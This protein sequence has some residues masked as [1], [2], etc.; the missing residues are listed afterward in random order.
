MT[1]NINFMKRF[2][3]FLL[4]A[5]VTMAFPPVSQAAACEKPVTEKAA[6]EK[7]AVEEPA[8][9]KPETEKSADK[10]VSFEAVTLRLSGMRMTME[11]EIV[12]NGEEAQVV[13]YVMRYE[14]K[15]KKRE[16]RR[17]AS[18]GADRVLRLLNRCELISWDGFAGKHPAGVLDGT[19]FTL[20]ACVN[21]GRKISAGG[22]EN[23]PKHFRELRNGLD[24]IL[25]QRG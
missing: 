18:C 5:A 10:I 14:K 8:V 7:P 19:A 12:M 9:E 24:A 13:E 2:F 20:K 23:F 15:E 22:S 4:L 25:R 17:K 6:A 1:M 21:G 3:A 11:Y 16:P